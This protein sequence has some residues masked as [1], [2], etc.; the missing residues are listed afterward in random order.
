MRDMSNILS[1]I[2]CE[3]DDAEKYLRESESASGRMA[4]VYRDLG[5][6]ELN[7]ALAIHS[8]AEQMK[9]NYESS[10]MTVPKSM[11]EIW[12]R[13]HENIMAKYNDLK[14]KLATKLATRI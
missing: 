1:L 7:H 2:E 9:S 8:E 14:S 4:E 6:Q 11:M 12:K 13:E 3:L 5:R 10:G